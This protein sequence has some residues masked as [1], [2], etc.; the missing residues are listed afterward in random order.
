[1]SCV[2][3]GCEWLERTNALA[4]LPRLVM[5]PG[6]PDDPTFGAKRCA[7]SSN[8]ALTMHPANEVERQRRCAV[9]RR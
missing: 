6:E 9:I 8:T 7:I 2:V 5:F 3:P 1:M 4:V